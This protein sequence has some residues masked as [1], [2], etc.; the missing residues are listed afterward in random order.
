MRKLSLR[1]W[2][3]CPSF[4]DRHQRCVPMVLKNGDAKHLVPRRADGSQ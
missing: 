1:D 3:I 2:L 4:I